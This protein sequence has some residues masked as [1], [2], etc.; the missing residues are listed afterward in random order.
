L[1]GHFT[2]NRKGSFDLKEI[3]NPVVQNQPGFF[4]TEL[5][6]ES[7]PSGKRKRKSP[8]NTGGGFMEHL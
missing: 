1:P 2:Y 6:S 3:E 5:I 4:V 7:P 8:V